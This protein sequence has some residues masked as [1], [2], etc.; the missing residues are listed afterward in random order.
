MCNNEGATTPPPH[1]T[2]P[3]S[4]LECFYGTLMEDEQADIE[5]KKFRI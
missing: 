1:H 5:A 4:G 3:G 2:T